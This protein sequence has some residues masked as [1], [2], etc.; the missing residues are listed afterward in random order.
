MFYEQ[1]PVLPSP[2]MKNYKNKN[3]EQQ[4]FLNI[5]DELTKIMGEAFPPIT[6]EDVQEKIN[7]IRKQF[8][9]QLIRVKKS[10][11]VQL[12]L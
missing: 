6:V 10:V 4:H 8:F 1:H 11:I 2:K 5:T 9:S 3:V 12:I 7:N